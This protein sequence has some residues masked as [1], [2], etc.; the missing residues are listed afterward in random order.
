MVVKLQHPDRPEYQSR[1]ELRQTQTLP[2]FETIGEPPKTT[3]EKLLSYLADVRAG[4]GSGVLLL[5]VNVFLLLFAYYL[6]KTVREALI[7][8]EGGA[9]IKAYSSAGQAALLMFLVPLYGFFGTKVVRIKLITGLLLFFAANL[10][11]F[12]LFGI[13][14][15][16]EG[17]VFYIWVGIFNCFVV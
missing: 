1:S 14:G 5:T 6:L 10:G 17:V 4:E 9:Y 2:R 15:F 8:T 3:T 11:A 13:R 7:L 12:Y 16:K